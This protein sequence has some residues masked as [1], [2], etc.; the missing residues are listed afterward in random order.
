M[1][2]QNPIAIGSEVK[3]KKASRYLSGRFF[4]RSY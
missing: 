4:I 1:Q 2:S 3:N